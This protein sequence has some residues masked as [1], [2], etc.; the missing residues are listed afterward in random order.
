VGAFT[1][2]KKGGRTPMSIRIQELQFEGPYP[3]T[4]SL[5]EI[6]GK[7]AIFCQKPDG[8]LHLL[9]YSNASNVKACVEKVTDSGLCM[10]KH[11]R[12]ILVFAALYLPTGKTE[13]SYCFSSI[14][15]N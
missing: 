5:N 7:Y 3:S 8:E 14:G 1:I 12:G 9:M 11:C 2:L 10:N 13:I 4:K 6:A 15:R